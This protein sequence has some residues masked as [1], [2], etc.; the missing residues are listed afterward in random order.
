MFANETAKGHLAMLLF[1]VFVAG[2]YALGN[3][4]AP[5]IDAT[6][7]MALRFLL[8]G[9]L[10]GLFVMIRT[11]KEERRMEGLWRYLL[12][13]FVFAVYFVSLF[14]ALKRTTAVSTGTMFTLVPFLTAGL[15]WLLLRQHSSRRVLLAL[16]I[17]AVGAVW[18][19]FRGNIG[20]L[21]AF[22]IGAG[23]RIFLIG[24]VAHALYV[25]LARMLGHGEPVLLFTFGVLIGGSVPLIAVGSPQILATDWAALPAIVWITLGY[26]VVFATLITFVLLQFGNLRLTGAKVM[27]YSYLVP[28]WVIV[29]N[30]ALGRGIPEPGILVGVALTIVAM[31]MLLRD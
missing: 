13:G 5:F 7:L 11:P 6:A 12:L 3:I 1:S 28:T 22:H 30:L 9:I 15:S 27:A 4:A 26:M 18:V 19:I 17:A 24:V 10:M 8:S 2:T 16:S 20:A 25:P 21:L 29:W 23:E 31:L 14:E